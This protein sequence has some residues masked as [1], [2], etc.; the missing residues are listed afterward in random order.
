MYYFCYMC[1]EFYDKIILFKCKR[2]KDGRFRYKNTGS[3]HL[4]HF[5]SE[6]YCA[7]SNVLAFIF[8][9]AGTKRD[10]FVIGGDSFRDAVNLISFLLLP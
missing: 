6:I 1:N 8:F 10:I 9:I 3:S 2:F 7:Q 5:S 4:N